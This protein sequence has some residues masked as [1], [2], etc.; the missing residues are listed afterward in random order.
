MDL[1]ITAFGTNDVNDGAGAVAVA[2][3]R[4]LAALAA[5]VPVLIGL[6]P[7]IFMASRDVN[8][9]VDAINRQLR[10]AFPPNQIVDLWTGFRH[11][12][13]EAPMHL[14]AAGQALRAERV[15][16]ALQTFTDGCVP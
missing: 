1:V 16:Q 12:F 7:P 8:P 13:Y 5:P 9:A 6:V 15:I 3:H 11:A 2:C 10:D 4:A 14:D